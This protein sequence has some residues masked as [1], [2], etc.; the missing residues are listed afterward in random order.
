[1][2]IHV[3]EYL[4]HSEK[5]RP[6]DDQQKFY[7]I[8]QMGR[9]AIYREHFAILIG[10]PWNFG[11]GACVCVWWVS[12]K[13]PERE[14]GDVATEWRVKRERERWTERWK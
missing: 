10:E 3:R 14:I 11:Y 7:Y 13:A 6:S 5:R 1:M 4:R 8:T 9:W 12:G 2:Q